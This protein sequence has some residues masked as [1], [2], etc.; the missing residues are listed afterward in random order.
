[1]AK[2]QD[3]PPRGAPAYML[4]FGDLMSLLL[5]FFVLLVSMASF[6]P[7]KFKM[8]TESLQG[9]FGVLQSYPTVPIHPF[10]Q[11]PLRNVKEAR[12]K[13]S[14]EDARRLQQTIQTKGLSESMKV[15]MTEKGIAIL[16]RNPS[17]FQSGSAELGEQGQAMIEDISNILKERPDL[18]VRVEGH[19]DDVPINSPQYRSNWEL[20][21]ARALTV[22]RALA[23]KTIIQPANMSAVGYG[24]FR[25]L[26]PNTDENNRSQNRRI[27]IFVDYVNQ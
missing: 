4:T 6:E 14:V 15:E 12:K 17:N 20:S 13:M 11:V 23:E 22:V 9:A 1:M 19:T 26:V 2:C 10:I 3:C 27:Q 5:T 7:V 25:P 21:S 8:A 24:E 18:S 16:L